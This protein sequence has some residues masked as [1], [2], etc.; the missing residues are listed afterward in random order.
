MRI[1]RPVT[2][3]LSNLEASLVPMKS[4]LLD[5][6]T[7]QLSRVDAALIREGLRAWLVNSAVTSLSSLAYWL[8][9]IDLGFVKG[10]LTDVTVPCVIQFTFIHD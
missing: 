7:S 4:L 1:C 3:P 2:L 6:S 8:R 10:D 9:G 5:A